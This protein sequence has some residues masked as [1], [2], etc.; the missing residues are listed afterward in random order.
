MINCQL[1]NNSSYTLEEREKLSASVF[2]DDAIP[3][4][5]LK[6]CNRIELYWGEGQ[7]SDTIIRHLY[8]IASGLE[9]SLIGERAIQGQL[10]SAYQ[11]ACNRYKLSA[12]MHRLFQTAMHTGK[13]VR[14]ETK[15]SEGAVSHSQITVEILKKQPI[16]L[17]KK[18][19]S[20]IGVNKLTEDILK[21]LT[22]NQAVNIF[23]SNRNFDKA[24]ALAK[25]YKGTAIGLE[26]KKQ[27]LEFTDVLICATS[28]PHTIIKKEDM[29]ADKEMLVFDLAFPRDVEKS[30][31][32]NEHIR[33]FDLE[34]I[35]Q[36][37]KNNLL[38]R[39]NELA[40]AEQIIED[41]M[42]RFHAWQSFAKK[43]QL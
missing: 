17:K 5:L 3:H 21:Y 1:I 33:L 38:L 43:L 25:Q 18:I 4:V 10:K 20:I 39:K 37:A 35:E 36:F 11:E 7:V 29:P 34:D 22:A 6:T 41:E 32:Q 24:Q 2:M 16:D 40:K 19:V 13:R 15:I 14:S 12:E 27:L 9:S 26:N 28:A 42:A 31:G 23:L 8:R 30:V